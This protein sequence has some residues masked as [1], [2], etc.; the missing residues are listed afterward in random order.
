MLV[1]P[2]LGICIYITSIASM[3]ITALIKPRSRGRM[4]KVEDGGS[5]SQGPRSK[6]DITTTDR[7]YFA[8]LILAPS[9]AARRPQQSRLVWPSRK[10]KFINTSIILDHMHAKS[11]YNCNGSHHHTNTLH[12]K[13]VLWVIITHIVAQL[14]GAPA[15]LFIQINNTI[16][17]SSTLALLPLIINE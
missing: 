2:L 7:S 12:F 3:E 15:S 1:L 5:P 13:I 11:T 8:S 10:K 6:S 9:M 14:L 17:P 16:V 4:E